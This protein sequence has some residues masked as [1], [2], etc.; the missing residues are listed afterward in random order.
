MSS[1][2][3]EI[4]KKYYCFDDK[5]KIHRNVLRST[6][7]ES[8]AHLEH[9]HNHYEILHCL[10]DNVHI[11]IEGEHYVV[12]KG[13]VVLI[14]KNELHRINIPPYAVY[15]RLVFEIAED[16]NLTLFPTNKSNLFRVFELK[17]Y[18]VGNLLNENI[19]NS[20]GIKDILSVIASSIKYDTFLDME[21]YANVILLLIELNRIYEQYGFFE[22]ISNRNRLIDDIIEYVNNNLY[23]RITLSDLEKHLSV[24]KF[25]ISHTFSKVFNIPLSQYIMIKK[26]SLAKKLIMQGMSPTEVCYKLEFSDYSIF[27]KNY[28]KITNKSP[29]DYIKSAK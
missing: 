1:M 10:G 28:K 7:S 5:I 11:T 2:S 23:K 26:I 9:V 4:I 15:D 6:T 27:Y 21:I 22:N 14:N 19:V 24:S 29:S 3:D 13:D 17:K 18:G 25:Y 16:A 8:I 12:S 20:S